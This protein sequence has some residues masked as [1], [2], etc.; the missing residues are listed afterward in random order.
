MA[1]IRSSSEATG[2]SGRLK[3]STRSMI[4]RYC[5]LNSILRVMNKLT[6]KI[7]NNDKQFNW[8]RAFKC[9]DIP[10]FIWFRSVGR[11][12]I[13][14]PLSVSWEGLPVQWMSFPSLQAL[15]SHGRCGNGFCPKIKC[16]ALFLKNV[17][18]DTNIYSLAMRGDKNIT[19]AL[20]KID[21]I[22]FSVTPMPWRA[23]QNMKVMRGE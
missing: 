20:R 6:Q 8:Y 9:H 17:L 16:Y 18:I 5:F 2:M 3:I 10:E 1:G 19:A 23:Q 12:L 13:K 11:C 14:R 15:L 22:G 7:I 4:R 21:Q